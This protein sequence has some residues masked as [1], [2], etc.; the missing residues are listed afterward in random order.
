MKYLHELKV[1]HVAANSEELD[2]IARYM[3][4]T[5]I[6]DG[7]VILDMDGLESSSAHVAEEL[8]EILKGFDGLIYVTR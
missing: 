5:A 1:A 3:N 8:R 2:Q 4:T 7:V 6:G